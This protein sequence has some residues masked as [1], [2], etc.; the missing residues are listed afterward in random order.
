MDQLSLSVGM[1]MNGWSQIEKAVPRTAVSGSSSLIS[2]DINY[3]IFQFRKLSHVFKM[4]GSG[5]LPGIE[6]YYGVGYGVRWYF[7]SEGT[8]VRLSGKVLDVDLTPKFR[9]YAGVN[10][11]GYYSVY[12]PEPNG[13][14]IRNDLG[15]EFGG[16]GGIMFGNHHKRAYKAQVNVFMGNG[17]E[18]SSMLIQF[19][20]GATFFLEPIF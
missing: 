17:S 11:G 6:K 3:E 16:H 8:R 7:G 20:F 18:T 15:V 10:V 14:E 13:V 5:I 2:A 19:F 4:T 9:Y 12:K 1:V